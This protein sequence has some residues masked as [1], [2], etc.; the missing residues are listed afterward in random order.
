[1][2]FV[3]TVIQR[4]MESS[5]PDYKAGD[6]L[7]FKETNRVCKIVFEV[8]PRLFLVEFQDDCS[9]SVYTKSE[10]LDFTRT[11]TLTESDY[12]YVD[13]VIGML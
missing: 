12:E 6:V 5:K 7:V 11:P 13:S 2:T 1:L 9:V 4:D 3:N 10:L 8:S